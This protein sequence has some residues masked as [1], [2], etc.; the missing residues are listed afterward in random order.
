MIDSFS[1]N[2]IISMVFVVVIVVVIIAMMLPALPTTYSVFDDIV[3]SAE[4][5]CN[6]N[7]PAHVTTPFTVEP[8]YFIIQVYND[9]FPHHIRFLK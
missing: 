5:A 9:H 1:M 8:G 2:N 3:A 6:P 7:Y 4:T